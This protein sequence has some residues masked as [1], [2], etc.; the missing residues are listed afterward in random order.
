MSENNIKNFDLANPGEY[1]RNRREELDLSQ[2]V[3]AALTGVSTGHL[4]DVEN[5]KKNPSLFLLKKILDV[6]NVKFELKEKAKLKPDIQK[7]IKD[8]SLELD[9]YK[10]AMKKLRFFKDRFID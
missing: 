3:L 4:S 2:D 8:Y 9:K 6:L 7:M 10:S 5:N 1:I